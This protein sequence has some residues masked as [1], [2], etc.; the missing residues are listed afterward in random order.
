[1]DISFLKLF[2]N[3]FNEAVNSENTP[4]SYSNFSGFVNI[5]PTENIIQTTNCDEDIAFGGN[6]KVEL[7][8]LCQ[9]VI[10]D[11]T[12]K[13]FFNEFTDLNGIK[14]I[15]FEIIPINED[16]HNE[17][18]FLK[19]S[20]TVS[21]DVWYSKSFT[22]S[23][24]ESNETS[25]FHYKNESFFEGVDYD[26]SN[27]FQSIRLKCF[28]TEVD[29]E[30]EVNEYTQ[31]SG[32]KI[33]LRPTFSNIEK[34][35]MYDCDNFTHQRLVR[36]LNHDIVY[37]NGRKISNKPKIEKQEKEGQSNIFEVTFEANSTNEQLGFVYGI[38]NPF[39]FEISNVAPKGD[40]SLNQFTN[41][42]KVNFNKT[43][44]LGIGS[45]R[46]YDL[47]NSL[48]QSF[49]ESQ[50][51]LFSNYFEVPTSSLALGEYYIKFSKGL[52]KSIFN[53]DIEINNSTEWML[54]ILNSDYS[55]S[56]YDSNDY[57]T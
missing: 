50:I 10:K 44:V 9:E 53:E 21:D 38:A 14:Q 2:K 8:D 4:D 12:N 55:N 56:D 1:M 7:I 45:L 13:F 32:N 3:D 19:I 6:F 24:F 25:I 15:Q 40:V 42:L 36:L 41:L 39:K 35:L 31:L 54:N 22:L 27:L 51:N 52:V 33:S 28:K 23:D 43:I 20:H 29:T 18:L 57:L 11:V 30:I 37:L 47:S 48:I 17:L 49:S 16:F 34:Y 5:L 46:I 26:K